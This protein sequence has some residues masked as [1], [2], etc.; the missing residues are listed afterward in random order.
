MPAA[1]PPVPD[2][3]APKRLLDARAAGDAQ[4]EDRRTR[5]AAKRARAVLDWVLSGS[6]ATVAVCALGVSLYQTWLARQ[7]QRASVWPRLE[8]SRLVND[9]T[10]VDGVRNVGLGPALVRDVRVTLDG[11]PVDGAGV[12]GGEALLRTLLD[13]ARM[14]ALGRDTAALP[15]LELHALASGQVLLPGA[16]VE[17]FVFAARG[18]YARA[19]FEAAE[20]RRL[21]TS[22]CYCSLYGD[23]W[24]IG[25]DAPP[26]GASA[27]DGEPTPVRACRTRGR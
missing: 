18:P 4:G 7:Q 17:T 2:D 26:A 10:Y 27:G 24:R 1:P 15:R 23:C 13:S 25:A 16:A 11:R 3:G 14:R 6:A 8:L 5:L 21:R 9:S 22:I 12:G 19:V 20:R